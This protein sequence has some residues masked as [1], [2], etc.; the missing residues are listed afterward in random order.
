MTVT[1]K[2]VVLTLG[3]WGSIWLGQG[4]GLIPGSFMTNQIGWAVAG[5]V[6]IAAA[7]WTWRS[8]RPSSDG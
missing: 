8:G 6:L 4:I 1:R 3:F 7:I 5:A 2:A